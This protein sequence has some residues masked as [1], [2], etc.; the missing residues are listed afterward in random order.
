MG[1][2]VKDST[3]DT[4]II[5]IVDFLCDECDQC[6]RCYMKEYAD[7]EFKICSH[8]T[9]KI[10]KSELLPNYHIRNCAEVPTDC[11]SVCRCWCFWTQLWMKP[12]ICIRCGGRSLIW[13]IVI[14][15]RLL[16]T[17]ELLYICRFCLDVFSIIEPVASPIKENG[18]TE[19]ETVFSAYSHINTCKLT[20]KELHVCRCTTEKSYS[21]LV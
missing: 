5:E 6:Y 12:A 7:G 9:K 18:S 4:G 11:D 10:E 8:R 21:N 2:K 19:E 20:P 13:F 16:S 1:A 14:P 3:I 17:V 15:L